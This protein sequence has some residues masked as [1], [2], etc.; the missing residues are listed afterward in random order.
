MLLSG[1]SLPCIFFN[2]VKLLHWSVRGN[3]EDL[4]QH[5]AS[6]SD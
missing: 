5:E 1:D 2:G 6:H 3:K 4:S